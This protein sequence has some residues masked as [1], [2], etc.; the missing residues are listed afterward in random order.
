MAIASPAPTIAAATTTVP[1]GAGATWLS[2]AR[3]IGTRVA[4]RNSTPQRE[5]W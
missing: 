2:P 3:R 4:G 1:L 5:H